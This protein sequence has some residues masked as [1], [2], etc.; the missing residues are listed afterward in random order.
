VN[1]KINE[2]KN[3]INEVDNKVT[4]STRWIKVNKVDNKVNDK[5]S[6]VDNK[7]NKMALSP[8]SHAHCSTSLRIKNYT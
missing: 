1:N 4:R 2:L 6:E 7:V 8:L 5:I 3:K